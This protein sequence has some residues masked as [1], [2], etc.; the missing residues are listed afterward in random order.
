M[1]AAAMP[2]PHPRTASGLFSCFDPR[3]AME[4][5]WCDKSTLKTS[6]PLLARMP[7]R[8]AETS[9]PTTH[10]DYPVDRL[11]V[12]VQSLSVN[13]IPYGSELFS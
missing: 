11:K 1:R 10:G 13:L 8:E 4:A 7:E 3:P 6:S 12:A 5:T 2:R 9:P